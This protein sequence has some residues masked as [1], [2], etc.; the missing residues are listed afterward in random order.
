VGAFAF[1]GAILSGGN[2]IETVGDSLVDVESIQAMDIAIA[3]FSAAIVIAVMTFLSIPISTTQAV[4]GSIASLGLI[5]GANVQWEKMTVIFVLGFLTPLAAFITSYLFQRLFVPLLLM[6]ATF[7]SQ[8]RTMKVTVLASGIFL[9]YTLGAN[10]VG[11]VVGLAVGK[12]ILTPIAGGV[13][14]GF[15]IAL[16]SATW[17]K[18]VMRTVAHDIT[19][20]DA[21]MALSAQMG[22]G[23]VMSTLTHFGIPTSFTFALIGAIAGVGATKGMHSIGSKTLWFIFTAWVLTPLLSIGLTLTLLELHKIMI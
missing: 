3:L 6:R 12:D 22:A 10:H 20:L 9:A 23:I 1:F 5:M 2:T 7:L 18:G 8:E 13:L 14:G 19:S 21:T 4:L 15:A 16:G 17:G 11:N